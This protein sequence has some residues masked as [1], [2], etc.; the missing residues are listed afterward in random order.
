MN[1]VNRNG[2]WRKKEIENN[3]KKE[4]YC[5]GQFANVWRKNFRLT[6]QGLHHD[7]KDDH[8]TSRFDLIHA[9]PII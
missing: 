9:M 3:N 6:L 5:R 7:T 8:D 2:E 4:Q 1:N